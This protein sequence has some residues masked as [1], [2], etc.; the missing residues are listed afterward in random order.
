MSQVQINY[1]LIS[2]R[3]YTRPIKSVMIIRLLYLGTD[4]NIGF[5]KKLPMDSWIVAAFILIFLISVISVMVIRPRNRNVNG[6][7]MQLVAKQTA[8]VRTQDGSLAIDVEGP[9]SQNGESLTRKEI[10]LSSGA[11]GMESRIPMVQLDGAIINSQ[12]SQAYN[13]YDEL[14]MANITPAVYTPL[15]TQGGTITERIRYPHRSPTKS[16]TLLC[17]TS[18]MTAIPH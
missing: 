16:W 17:G 8:N 6:V 12:F 4:E 1:K 18:V 9:A 2:I 7:N 13:S 15:G 5:P 10:Q 11:T 3:F 14:N